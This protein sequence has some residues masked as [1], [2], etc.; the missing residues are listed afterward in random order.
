MAEDTITPGEP[1]RL[2]TGWRA[3][4]SSLMVVVA[5]AS[6]AY[7]ALVTGHI[8][9]TAALFVGL[10]LLI[11]FLATHPSGTSCPRNVSPSGKPTGSR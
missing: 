1:R 11:G 9:Q 7:R 10:P 6:I 2:S 4:L 8:E 3:A 5:A